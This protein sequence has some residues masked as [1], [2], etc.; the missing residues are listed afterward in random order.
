MRPLP[1]AFSTWQ[2]NLLLRRRFSATKW[3]A[4]AMLLKRK[5]RGGSVVSHYYLIR[6][7]FKGRPSFGVQTKLPGRNS[8]NIKKSRK[9]N[10]N[11]RPGMTIDFNRPLH[12]RRR[13]ERGQRG[14][15][16]WQNNVQLPGQKK[17]AYG[18][19]NR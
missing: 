6:M 7:I 13:R 19:R 5:K 3:K 11:N 4:C 2:R 9:K 12:V 16:Y 18:Q 8:V 10:N 15:I 17:S 1:S 14:G